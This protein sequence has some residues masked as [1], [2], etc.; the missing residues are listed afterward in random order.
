MFY[1]IGHIYESKGY[2]A[3]P[4][5]LWIPVC[6]D[7]KTCLSSYSDKTHI[8]NCTPIS[9]SRNIETIC[10]SLNVRTSGYWNSCYCYL[11]EFST[12]GCVQISKNQKVCPFF[13]PIFQPWSW[14][15]NEKYSI[16]YPVWGV[17]SQNLTKVGK[18]L[19]VVPLLQSFIVAASVLESQ[20]RFGPKPDFINLPPSTIGI[21]PHNVSVGQKKMQFNSQMY[22]LNIV[23]ITVFH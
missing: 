11:L 7:S 3:R 22:F 4:V 19:S 9:Q 8:D 14:C 20:K 23:F 13:K 1:I 21:W 12:N 6:A 16:L 5:Y 18:H 10:S 17:E 2:R 15:A